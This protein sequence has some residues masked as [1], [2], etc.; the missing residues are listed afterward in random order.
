VLAIHLPRIFARFAPRILTPRCVGRI[1]LLAEL[2][3]RGLR[4]VDE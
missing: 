1:T 2:A 4:S 3:N